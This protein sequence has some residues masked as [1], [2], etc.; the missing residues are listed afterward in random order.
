MNPTTP[1]R[2][3]YTDLSHFTRTMAELYNEGT[4]EV[5]AKTKS[6]WDPERER[7]QRRHQG[8]EYS[9]DLSNRC[10]T[11]PFDGSLVVYEIA[12]SRLSVLLHFSKTLRVIAEIYTVE[13]TF[14]KRI[15]DRKIR[16]GATDII[17]IGS[18]QFFGEYVMVLHSCEGIKSFR[19]RMI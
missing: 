12:S 4:P 17:S 6:N 5:L 11:N 1:A 19:I 2:T 3:N 10:R 9:E 16:H 14:L 7:I 13:G 15:F 18:Q 8:L